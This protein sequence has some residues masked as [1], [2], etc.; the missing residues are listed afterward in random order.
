MLKFLPALFLISAVVHADTVFT[1][2]LTTVQTTVYD[3]VTNGYTVYGPLAMGFSYDEQ[4]YV[5]AVPVPITN[6]SLADFTSTSLYLYP[7]SGGFDGLDVFG[8]GS[9]GH[10]LV[11]GY[12]FPDGS[13]S[14][15]GVHSLF[16]PGD[17]D[18]ALL[19]VSGA[20]EPSSFGFVAVALL[21]FFLFARQF[22]F[23]A[24]RFP[25]RLRARRLC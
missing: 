7:H 14:T 20:P 8:T 23:A 3:T 11:F 22:G 24:F 13:L 25:A 16:R 18:A 17:P 10:I 21:A 4:T 2:T 5:Y 19:T 15:P 6:F 9:N 1:E 12:A